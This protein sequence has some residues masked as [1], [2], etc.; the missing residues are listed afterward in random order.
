MNNNNHQKA[1][2][3]WPACQD[4]QPLVWSSSLQPP[5]AQESLRDPPTVQLWFRMSGIGYEVQIPNT[6]G[7]DANADGPQKIV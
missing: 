7:R 3:I 2:W 5:H 1:D 4:S 6:L